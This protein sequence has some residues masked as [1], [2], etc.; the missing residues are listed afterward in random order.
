MANSSHKN[1]KLKFDSEK[2]SVKTSNEQ[3]TDSLTKMINLKI[4]KNK[5]LFTYILI[6][7]SSNIRKFENSSQS[8]RLGQFL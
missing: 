8:M 7:A 3:N 1:K 2:F 6:I 5:K 4:T